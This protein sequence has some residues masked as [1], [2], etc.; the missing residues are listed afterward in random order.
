MRCQQLL[1]T[2]QG[3]IANGTTNGARA[4]VF[5]QNANIR[6]GWEVWLQLEIAHGFLTIGGNWTCDREWPYPSTNAG[7]PFLTYAAA[8][9]AWGTTANPVAAARADFYLRRAAIPA[10]DVYIE[11]KCINPTHATP[12]QDAWNR[13]NADV[14]KQQTLRGGNAGLNY[15]SLLASFGTFQAGD[16][17]GPNPALGWYWGGGRSA[18]VYDMVNN[19]VSTLA[20][21]AQGGAPRL[22]LVA[23]S[24]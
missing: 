11:L 13:F 3:C 7:A 5:G 20:N 12:L 22:F 9:P 21:V 4:A 8:G 2:I 14:V 19:Q 24:V 23:V 18:Y 15:V 17:A 6:G 1:N 16:V 10:D